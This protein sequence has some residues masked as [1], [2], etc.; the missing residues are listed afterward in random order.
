M[1]SC[2]PRRGQ[3]LATQS[4][5]CLLWAGASHLSDWVFMCLIQDLKDSFALRL[6]LTPTSVADIKSRRLRAGVHTSG[7]RCSVLGRFGTQGCTFTTVMLLR[8]QVATHVLRSL[9]AT[10]IG[11][12]ERRPNNVYSKFRNHKQCHLY[13]RLDVLNALRLGKHMRSDGT[14]PILY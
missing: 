12:Q 7:L 10:F 13:K 9:E 5:L 8:I 1:R 6:N 4:S 3:R 2:A 14:G 11:R